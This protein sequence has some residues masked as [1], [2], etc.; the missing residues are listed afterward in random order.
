MTV[1]TKVLTLSILME[2]YFLKKNWGLKKMATLS[3][4]AGKD[5]SNSYVNASE[6]SDSSVSVGFSASGSGNA[7]ADVLIVLRDSSDN[8]VW[9]A[10]QTN[11]GTTNY[12]KLIPSSLF[13]QGSYTLT[14]YFHSSGSYSGTSTNSVAAGT[15]TLPS[16]GSVQS[17]TTTGATLATK[18]FTYDTVAPNAA[19]LTLAANV[20]NGGATNTEATTNLGTVNAE[21]GSTVTLTYTDQDGDTKTKT[22][23]ADGTDQI[24]N[25]VSGD[26]TGGGRLSDG[27]INVSVTVSDAAGNTSAATTG[28]FVYDSSA[29]AA[30]TA[31]LTT[32]SG[33]SSSDHIT[34]DGA[35]TVG[36]VEANAV[37]EYSTDGGINWST[38]KPAAV[39]GSNSI[40]VRQSDAAGNVSAASTLS[41][42]LDTALSPAA[43]LALAANVETGGATAGEATTQ[44][45]T[46]TTESG[47]AVTVQYTD[48]TVTKT[49]TFT[50]TGSDAINLASGDIG[51]GSGTRLA[52]GT[53]NV[54]VSVSDAAGNTSST[55]GSFVLDTNIPLAPTLTLNSDTGTLDSDN[56]TNDGAYTVGNVEADAVVEYST[57]GGTNW[58]TT[59]PAA[60]EGSN[61]IK[62]RQSDAAGNVSSASTLSFTLDTTAPADATFTNYYVFDVTSPIYEKYIVDSSA[63]FKG[64]VEAG[65]KIANLTL[66]DENGDEILSHDLDPTGGGQAE[67][68]ADG[69]WSFDATNDPVAFAALEAL[70]GENCTLIITSEDVAGNQTTTSISD[71]YVDTNIPP[72]PSVSE[73]N[74]L[75]PDS[76]WQ[77]D[78]AVLGYVGDVFVATDPAAHVTAWIQAG[79]QR[80]YEQEA[81]YD[82]VVGQFVWSPTIDDSDGDGILDAADPDSDGVN[83]RIDL[84]TLYNPVEFVLAAQ[85]DVGNIVTIGGGKPAVVNVGFGAH[86]VELGDDPSTPVIYDVDGI[87]VIGGVETNFVLN[88]INDN[89]VGS[90]GYDDLLIGYNGDDSLNGQGGNDWLYGG[91][92]ADTIRGGAGNDTI[93]GGTQADRLDG[94]SGADTFIYSRF[95]ESSVSAHD[96]IV[97]FDAVEGDKISLAEVFDSLGVTG[98]FKNYT[99]GSSGSNAAKVKGKW[100]GDTATT[101]DVWVGDDG[102]VYVNLSGDNKAEIGIYLVTPTTNPDTGITTDVAYADVV[103]LRTLDANLDLVPDWLIL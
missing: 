72:V 32:D 5:I 8:V 18:T 49:K 100:V 14:G 24:I 83:A 34:N 75:P 43:S 91:Q 29:P 77:H 45:G 80:V 20:A 23:T 19:T 31:T 61:S 33:S 76:K 65:I 73:F 16:A 15:L 94:G 55:S 60:V 98:Q 66:V 40:E 38:T 26:F 25:L 92:G 41:F 44:L 85:D 3:L 46:L 9:W 1:Y 17:W 13:S 11:V 64:T 6:V 63:T 89:L 50:S 52:D 97:N 59:K 4:L 57:D 37:V 68:K 42:T 7:S 53:I 62:V 54:S 39:E 69:S 71:V 67:L 28:S 58:S 86:A 93:A 27:T 35:Y 21:S 87:T 51:T 36:N 22:L 30:P 48:G 12:E 101:G 81:V 2:A 10:T 99:F 102:V 90:N 70:N 96:T 82:P 56:I 78:I 88:N 95:N 84:N 79:N 74:F 103:G 47:A